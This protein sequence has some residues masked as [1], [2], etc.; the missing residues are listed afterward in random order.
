MGITV[1]GVATEADP[2]PRAVPAHVPAR[3]RAL[4]G[5]EGLRRR[6]LRRLLGAGRRRA[7]ALLRVSRRCAP[8]AAT[9]PP[10]PGSARRTTCT[11]C[12][13][14][15]STPQGFQCGFCTAGMIMTASA[16]TDDAARGPAARCSRATCAAAPATG[17]S[18]T[19]CA[20]RCN[21]EEPAT[22]PSRPLAGAPAGRRIVTGTEP[23][24]AGPR[25]SPGCCTSRVLR[26]PARARADRRRSTPPPREAMPG[27]QLVLTHDD[28][29]AR[30]VLDRAGT[31]NRLDDPDDTRVLDD[32]VRFVGQRVAA[33]VAESL[34]Q[35]PRRR[36]GRSTSSTRCCPR[37][38]TPRRP[39]G[40]GR[41]AGARRQGG[42]RA[43]RRPVAQHRRRAARRRRR[44]RPPA[45]RRGRRG[46][47]RRPGG[48]S[49]SQHAHLE[50]HGAV[51]WLDERRPAGDCAPA[52]RCRSWSATSCA[53]S[54]ACDRSEVRVFTA[55]VG[56][57]F[58]G[59]QEMLTE[60][61]VALAV[62]RTG[63]PVQ[64]R[65][66]AAPTSSP[67]HRAGTRSGSTS[68]VGGRRRRR[69]DRAGRRRA[70]PTPARTA[71]T[72]RA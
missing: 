53:T 18:R 52:P 70:R 31:T 38:S 37:C 51:G 6:R 71:T 47:R 11:R 50:T 55:R 46:R 19:R 23:L 12:S 64:L 65:V 63:R 43:D 59:K 33:V 1:N 15:S 34:A 10:S 4:R 60:D 49:A 26:T 62:L 22:A 45:R 29:P 7:G 42:R 44:R 72:A 36:A 3:A 28:V 8:R 14:G 40:A 13:S 61:L 56:G 9:S 66:H 57:G 35:S 25:A 67:R 20:A 41:A 2:R 39:R 48:P 27:V 58:G 17:R 16:L 54:S 21:T 30:A 69:A 24:H 5:Q 68:R 32:V